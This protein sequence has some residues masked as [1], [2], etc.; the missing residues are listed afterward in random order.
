MKVVGTFSDCDSLSDEETSPRARPAAAAAASAASDPPVAA[1]SAVPG[2]LPA[3]QPVAATETRTASPADASPMLQAQMPS[4]L[5]HI[6]ADAEGIMGV[7]FPGGA[8]PGP[9]YSP[10]VE[11]TRE[12][13]ESDDDDTPGGG[14]LK[15]EGLI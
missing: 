14:M 10:G 12:Y 11:S 5:P 13:S 15:G 6:Q 9:G 2:R 3:L 1:P 7:D 8:P 4:P